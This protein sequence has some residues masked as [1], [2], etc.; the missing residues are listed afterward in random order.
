M[1]N[2]SAF[3][4][5][6]FNSIKK[7][8][9]GRLQINWKNKT[10]STVETTIFVVEYLNKSKG[11]SFYSSVF[12]ALTKEFFIFWNIKR[13]TPWHL[14]GILCWLEITISSI[15]TLCFFDGS[16]AWKK[17]LFMYLS[18]GIS[19]QIEVERCQMNRSDLFHHR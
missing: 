1:F 16:F 6:I 4:N 12:D 3:S 11:S 10:L 5:L 8:K 14:R 15:R 19:Y 2:C 7:S 18:S 13:K 9:N 17:G